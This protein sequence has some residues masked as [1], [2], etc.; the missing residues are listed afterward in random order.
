MKKLINYYINRLWAP[1]L[2]LF[3]TNIFDTDCSFINYTS[4]YSLFWKYKL[5]IVII[6]IKTGKNIIINFEEKFKLF[7]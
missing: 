2:K 5:N 1:E 3:K 4:K 6:K 7:L